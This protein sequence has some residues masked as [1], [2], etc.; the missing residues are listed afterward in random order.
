MVNGVF[1]KSL[2]QGIRKKYAY[3]RP[4]LKPLII[5]T[6]GA[7]DFIREIMTK[8]VR[9]EVER[10]TLRFR[11]TKP[12]QSQQRERQYAVQP[13][14]SVQASFLQTQTHVHANHIVYH[15]YT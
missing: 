9:E 14:A 12:K 8:S 1:L 15:N 2:D 10:H 11:H 13:T 4:D 6:R 7:N 5:N 3:D